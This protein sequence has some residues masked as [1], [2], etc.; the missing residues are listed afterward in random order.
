MGCLTWVATE[1]DCEF[2]T[3]AAEIGGAPAMAIA[4]FRHRSVAKAGWP[5]TLPAVAQ[6]A[7]DAKSIPDRW[8]ML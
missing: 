4:G 2:R 6:G 7:D 8:P 3:G 1:D 5:E